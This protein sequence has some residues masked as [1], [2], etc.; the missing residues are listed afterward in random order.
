[1]ADAIASKVEINSSTPTRIW[2][3]TGSCKITFPQAAYVGG[4]AVT[5]ATGCLL[6]SVLDIN[7]DHLLDIYAL[8]Y[9]DP[10]I[11]QVLEL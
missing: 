6:G 4:A 7:T 1:M 3:G 8:A 11:V 9:S 10:F 2:S 5:P